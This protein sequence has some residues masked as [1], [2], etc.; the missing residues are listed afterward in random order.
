[1]TTGE[2]TYYYGT[3]ADSGVT[4]CLPCGDS[5]DNKALLSIVS[6]PAVLTFLVLLFL[7]AAF[8]FASIFGSSSAKM[9]QKHQLLLD[10]LTAESDVITVRKI[11]KIH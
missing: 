5:I 2:A 3:G 6:T 10:K 9:S 8:A 11:G 1:V 4:E 7:V